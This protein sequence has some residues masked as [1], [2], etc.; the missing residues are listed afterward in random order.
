M[1]ASAIEVQEQNKGAGQAINNMQ[2]YLTVNY[3]ICT[4]GLY[5]SRN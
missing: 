5:P 4:N 3:I 2:P 1:D